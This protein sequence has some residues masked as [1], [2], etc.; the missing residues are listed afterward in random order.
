MGCGTSRTTGE[1]ASNNR[2]LSPFKDPVEPVKTDDPIEN[3]M[4]ID[5]LIDIGK[6]VV[7][8]EDWNDGENDGGR[9]NPG[10]VMEVCASKKEI[11]V[12]WEKTGHV[13][14]YIYGGNQRQTDGRRATWKP[15]Y[16]IQSQLAYNAMAD[17]IGLGAHM[18]LTKLRENRAS[19]NARNLGNLGVAYPILDQ[20]TEEN[21]HVTFLPS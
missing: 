3:T 6:M 1:P 20:E 8:G 12:R 15:V 14:K 5:Q 4:G 11:T 9:G 19:Q 16:E 21:A 18:P 10:V 17:I 13:G 7:R 2:R